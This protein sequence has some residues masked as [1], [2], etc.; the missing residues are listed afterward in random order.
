[1][2]TLCPPGF[3]NNAGCRCNAENGVG[4]AER[5]LFRGADYPRQDPKQLSRASA[6]KVRWVRGVC[7]DARKYL[8]C[9]LAA[10]QRDWLVKR[11]CV[12]YCAR[13]LAR[14]WHRR[15]ASERANERAMFVLLLRMHLDLGAFTVFRFS[16]EADTLMRD[17]MLLD[18]EVRKP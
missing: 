13:T 15:R 6:G 11:D 16:T 18:R 4:G 3:R 5:H 8:G 14:R 10:Q 12:I 1:M 2:N 9:F 7:R 17:N